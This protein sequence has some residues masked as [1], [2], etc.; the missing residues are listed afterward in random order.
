MSVTLAMEIRP[1]SSV[2]GAE[3]RGLDLRQPLSDAAYREVRDAFLQYHVLVFREQHLTEA[4]QI[5]FARRWGEPQA[6]PRR[7][8][9]GKGNPPDAEAAGWCADGSFSPRR[10]VATVLYAQAVPSIGG[11]TLFANTCMAYETLDDRIKQRIEQLRA[12]HKPAGNGVAPVEQPPVEQPMVRT[13]P[14]TG[15]KAIYLG[16]HANAIAGMDANA[17]QVLIRAVNAHIVL[18]EHLYAYRWRPGDL[19]MWDPRCVLHADTEF[20]WQHEQRRLRQVTVL[21]EELPA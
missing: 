11:N 7:Q 15:R 14:E 8:C 17:G 4:Q 6:R 16:Q 13:I 9:E 12:L 21:G 3:I 10:P 1:L 2:L 19:L 20:D 5:A 18:P